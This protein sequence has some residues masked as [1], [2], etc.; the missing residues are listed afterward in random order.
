MH[1][2]PFSGTP[3]QWPMFQVAYWETTR[4]YGYSNL[5]NLSRLQKLTGSA[6]NLVTSLLIYPNNV[7]A[8]VSTF[9][10]HFGRPEKLIRSQIDKTK[11]FP[12]IKYNK[13]SDLIEFSVLT[14]SLSAFLENSNGQPHLNNPTLSNELAKKLPMK[15]REDWEKYLMEREI[16]YPSVRQY[17]NWL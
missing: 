3:E 17:S 11:A 2:P 6:K 7:D 5:E 1:L 12:Q 10:H 9:K 4:V 15:K 14:A 16:I 8:V 13:M